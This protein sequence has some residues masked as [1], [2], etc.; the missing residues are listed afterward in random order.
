MWLFGSQTEFLAFLLA[1]GVLTVTPGVDTLMVI[2]NSLRGGQ[3]HGWITSLGICCG[4][5]VHALVSAAGLSFILAQSALAFSIMKWLG[6][7]YL[8]W[9]GWQSIRNDRQ[10]LTVD[11][12]DPAG[13]RVSCWQVLR[14]GFF[15]NVLNPKTAVFYLAFLPQF[16]Q[17]GDPVLLKSLWMALLHFVL[18][19][20]WQG[21][22]VMLVNLIRLLLQRGQLKVWLDRFAGV[23]LIGLGARLGLG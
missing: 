17:V 15:S 4:L 13:V 9:L 14:E 20:S 18:A 23:V 10:V 12:G 8:I 5:F 19:F 7:A 16:I 21:V 6:A 22:V 3:Q 1:I 2:R 11:A